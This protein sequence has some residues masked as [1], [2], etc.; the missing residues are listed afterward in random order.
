MGVSAWIG[1]FVR[2]VFELMGVPFEDSSIV[3]GRF[4]RPTALRWC[5]QEPQRL[6]NFMGGDRWH[7]LYPS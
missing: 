3:F 2:D 5:G 4:L 6:E 1:I 7:L